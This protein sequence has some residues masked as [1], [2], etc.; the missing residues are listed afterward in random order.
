MD[1]GTLINLMQEFGLWPDHEAIQDAVSGLRQRY[2]DDAR[3]LARELMQRNLLTPYQVNALFAGKGRQLVIGSYV[4]QERLGEGGMGQVFKAR[5]QGTNNV[6]ALKVIRQERVANPVAVSRYYREVQAATKMQHPNIVRTYDAGQADGTYYLAMEYIKGVDLSGYVKHRG[7]LPVRQA[8]QFLAQAAGGLQHIH[9]HNL[10]HRDIKPGNLFLEEVASAVDNAA[11]GKQSTSL[12]LR[13]ALRAPGSAHYQL[14]ILDLGLARISEEDISG[15]HA[16]KIALT[17]E[18]AVMGT[19]DYMAPEQARDCRAAD[20]RSDIYSLGCTFYFALTGH[21]PFPG[22]SAIEKI[23]HHQLDEPVMLEKFRPDLPAPVRAILRRMM[24][25]PPADRFQTP[26][27]VVAAVEPL[28]DD[29]GPAPL[30]VPVALVLEA[31]AGAVPADTAA[32]ATW[33]GGDGPAPMAIPLEA[34]QR[35]TLSDIGGETDE[36]L[37]VLD[38]PPVPPRGRNLVWWVCLGVLGSGA[39]VVA[40]FL[41]AVLLKVLAKK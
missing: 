27:E 15:E 5:Q 33:Q 31:G 41:F 30:A 34:P 32:L 22:G 9:E 6:V 40:V 23:L 24:A 19:A 26:A 37:V 10:V 39:A 14:R 35:A 11:P 8:C 7:P 38:R 25:K 12:Q 4:I 20:I 21:V 1:S 29:D 3:G 18:G 36:P 2:A 28:C 13:S 16:G 17:Q